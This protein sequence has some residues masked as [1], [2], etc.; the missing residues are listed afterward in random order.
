MPRRITSLQRRHLLTNRIL[1][2]RLAVM[3]FCSHCVS[4]GLLYVISDDSEYYVE[5]VRTYR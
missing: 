4:F 1:F 3:R 2:I 5:C